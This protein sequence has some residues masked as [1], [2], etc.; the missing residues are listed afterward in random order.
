VAWL[1]RYH[2]IDIPATRP[3]MDARDLDYL[4]RFLVPFRRYDQG[5]KSMHVVPPASV[6][7]RHRDLVERTFPE[8]LVV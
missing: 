1:V 3:Y 2:S 4:Q 8:P 6:L 7:D 5:T